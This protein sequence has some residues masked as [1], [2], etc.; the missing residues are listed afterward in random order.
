M[1]KNPNCLGLNKLKN[2]VDKENNVPTQLLKKR[3][4]K[5]RKSFPIQAPFINENR[6]S[7]TIPDELKKIKIRPII[8]KE[9]KS[10]KKVRK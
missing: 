3:I 7:L 10:V 6:V 9:K 1:L 4:V 8:N 2:Q 5:K